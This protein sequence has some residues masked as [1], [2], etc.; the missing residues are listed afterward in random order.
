MEPL[1]VDGSLGKI[2]PI[3]LK[4]QQLRHR[5]QSAIRCLEA[6]ID[7]QVSGTAVLDAGTSAAPA[8]KGVRCPRAKLK[9]SGAHAR[10]NHPEIVDGMPLGGQLAWAESR[11]IV[12][13]DA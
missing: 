3:G 9:E 6:S 1:V 12:G 2:G 4:L 8:P 7:R 5:H 13:Q 11:L 10:A